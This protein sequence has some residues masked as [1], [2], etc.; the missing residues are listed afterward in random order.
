MPNA[1][2][3]SRDGD[4]VKLTEAKWNRFAKDL[5]QYE[6]YYARLRSDFGAQAAELM[7]LHRLVEH[8]IEHP[9]DLVAA[10]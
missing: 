10:R 6:G 3:T 4:S 2:V 9:K 8:K 7:V 5:L 1:N